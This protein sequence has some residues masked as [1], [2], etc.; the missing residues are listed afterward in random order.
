MPLFKFVRVVRIASLQ[1][2]VQDSQLRLFI[3][4]NILMTL[5]WEHLARAES[6]GWNNAERMLSSILW[7]GEKDAVTGV[8]L[9]MLASTHLLTRLERS[10][11]FNQGVLYQLQR[12]TRSFGRIEE[13]D[14]TLGVFLHL[15]ADN[16]R[17]EEKF[18]GDLELSLL[19]GLMD[20][21]EAGCSSLA[22]HEEAACAVF[23]NPQLIDSAKAARLIV[24][25]TSRDKLGDS[26][27]TYELIEA[28]EAYGIV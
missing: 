21:L 4:K 16:L 1:E 12:I 24:L 26:C 27:E 3:W 25:I 7:K 17:G 2:A 10:A 6:E 28:D 13:Y 9:N 11:G 20:T 22:A 18:V 15:L 23:D 14:G 19:L 5:C 8:S